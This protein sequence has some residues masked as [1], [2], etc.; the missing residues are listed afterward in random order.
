[1]PDYNFI[2]NSLPEFV[3]N[4]AELISKQLDFGAPTI[5]KLTKQL[6]IK[7]SAFVNYLAVD[8]PIQDGKGCGFTPDG[9]AE[10]T[11]R[12][13]VTALFKKNLKVCPD[14]LIGKWAE[15]E[16]RIPA[17]DREYLPFEAY[18]VAEIIKQTAE[19][20]EELIWSGKS[21][22]NGGTDL[23]DGFLTIAEKEATVKK[24]AVAAGTSKLQAVRQVME[25]LPA[26]V[27]RAKPTI[28]VSPEFF[29][30]LGFELVDAN[31][32]HFAPSD[33][34]DSLV[35]PGTG[36]EVVSTYGLSGTDKVFASLES[37]MF[38]G[39]DVED[40]DRRV[41]VA[42]DRINKYFAIDLR[43]NAGV[44]VAFPDRV[45]VATIAK[46]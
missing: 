35:F 46:A 5:K 2:V 27:L 11:N 42:F 17:T 13:I 25:A 9:T 23:I 44:Q 26:K 21:A 12:K 33:N 41:D 19:Q 45:V 6:G 39:C 16:T 1:M 18:L 43:W 20:M 34:S 22:E 7:S 40:A 30:G 8:V 10:I 31:L 3:K 32:Y 4:N 28:F 15:Y 14:T 29:Q 37:N 38:Y 36:I 24:V